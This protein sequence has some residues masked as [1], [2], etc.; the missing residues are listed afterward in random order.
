M[1]KRALALASASRP[2]I[3]NV[4]SRKGGGRIR[5]A[6]S[7]VGAVARRAGRSRVARAAVP[8]TGI[9]LGGAL[10]GYVQSK[11][12]LD[13]LP[14]IGGSKMLT[15]GLAGYAVTRFSKNQ[16]IRTAGLAA[17]AVA[18]FDFGAKQGGG[19]G[20]KGLEDVSDDTAGDDTAGDDY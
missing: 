14:T 8:V 5:R 6:A 4:P 12:M 19:G 13:K 11:G 2:V 20:V 16:T 18:A 7:R 1:A 17:L 9:A 15:L 3:I 10:V